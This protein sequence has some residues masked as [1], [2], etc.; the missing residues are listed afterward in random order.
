MNGRGPVLAIIAAL[1]ACSTT[2]EPEASPGP[3]PDIPT[4]LPA[5]GTPNAVVR[6]EAFE[7]DDVTV[8]VDT[9]PVT[10]HEPDAMMAEI[11]REA[12]A[13]GLPMIAKTRWRVRWRYELDAR[14]GG[15]CD[16]NEPRS[17]LQVTY[18]LPDFQPETEPPAEV[19]AN[20]DRFERDLRI[21]EYGHGL[22]GLQAKRAIDAAMRAQGQSDTGDCDAL[23]ETLN[24]R[25]YA[26]IAQKRDAAYDRLT[27]NGRTQG[28]VLFLDSDTDDDEDTS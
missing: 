1:A 23:G 11:R 24:T 9:Y 18:I 4:A 10:Q 7:G 3:P 8:I 15:G 20:W 22:I 21:H 26:I 6:P 2:T 14:E 12:A 27:R 5:P 19:R 28:A 16:A 17:T 13:K 25:L